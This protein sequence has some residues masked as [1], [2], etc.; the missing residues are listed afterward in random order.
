[1]TQQNPETLYQ[2]LLQAYGRQRWWPARSALAMMAGAILVQNTAWVGAAKAVA[3]LEEAGL[4]QGA[5]LRQVAD[6]LLWERIRPAGFFRIKG[7]RLRALAQ[8]LEAYGDDCQ[9]LFQLDT[10]TLRQSLLNIHGV[11]KETADS[12]VCYG[13]ARPVFVV[14]AYTRRLFHRLGWTPEK[15]EYDTLQLLVMAAMPRD[16]DHLAEFHALIVRHA[17]RHCRAKPRCDG[18]PVVFCPKRVP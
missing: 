3:R 11:G 17:K 4:L 8:F 7:K 13:G 9:R 18:C 14:D 15:A 10:A 6:E 5:A 1:M 16:A 12:I 2:V